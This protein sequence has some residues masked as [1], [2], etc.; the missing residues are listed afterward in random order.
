M[1]GFI[2]QTYEAAANGHGNVSNIAS[3]RLGYRCEKLTAL[4]R[5]PSQQMRD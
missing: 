1:R 4:P 5:N 2:H 3:H